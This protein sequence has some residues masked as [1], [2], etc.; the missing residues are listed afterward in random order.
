MTFE[1]FDGTRLQGTFSGTLQALPAGSGAPATVT[2]GK[3]SL[4]L[5]GEL[6]T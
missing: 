4:V 3:F 1:S 5:E 6:C 2:N